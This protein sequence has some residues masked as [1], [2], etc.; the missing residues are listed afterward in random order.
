M[1]TTTDPA[2]DPVAEQLDRLLRTPPRPVGADDLAAL[3]SLLQDAAVR[4]VQLIEGHQ[5]LHTLPLRLPK[6][7]VADL[8]SCEGLALA[9]FAAPRDDSTSVPMLRGMALDRFV[10][11]ELTVGSVA[12]PYEDLL[13]M[14]DAQAE[15]STRDQVIAARDQLDLAPLAAAARGWAGLDPA[16]WARTQTAAAVHLVDGSVLCEGR[17]DVEVGGP[18]TD[19]PGV[20]VEVKTGRPHHGHL[21]EVTH[22][23]LLVALRDRAAPAM[24]ARWYPGGALAHLPVTADVLHSAAIRLATAIG[25]WAELQ[26]GRT[27]HL[28]SGP[29]C[30]WCPVADECNSAVLD[31]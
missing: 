3:R 7:R 10:L 22:Y 11:H 20:V 28:K 16:W 8:F 25:V 9:R 13:S 6:G 29:A 21:D 5:A 30:N 15:F 26:V 2:V 14:L 17:V 24:A 12:D 1:T 4:A 23:A 19:R 27:P 18:L 31:D